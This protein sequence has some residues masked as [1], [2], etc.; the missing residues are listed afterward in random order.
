[1][2]SWFTSVPSRF[3]RLMAQLSPVDVGAVDRQP[4]G[5]VP[6]VTD[7]TLVDPGA[8]GVGTADTPRIFGQAGVSLCPVDIA[9][10]AGRE[11]CRE[12]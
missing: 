2:K 12:N 1:M 8:V 4:P 3:A 6:G 7:E 11:G 9:F 10:G 5:F